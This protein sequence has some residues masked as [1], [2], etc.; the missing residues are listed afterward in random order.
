MRGRFREADGHL[1][2]AGLDGWQTAAVADGCFQRVRATGQPLR[3]PIGFTVEA[4]QIHIDFP[5]PLQPDPQLAQRWQVEQWNYRYSKEYGSDHY[6][7]SRP[8]EVGH[9]TVPVKRAELSGDGKRVTL[10][11]DELIPVMQMNLKARLR[12]AAGTPFDVDLFNTIH[13]TGVQ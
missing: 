12:T 4:N 1:Y 10:T 3:Q 2:V 11:F 9:D 13:A 6:R 7:V 5:Q 8:E